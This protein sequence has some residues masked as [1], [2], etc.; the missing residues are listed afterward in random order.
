MNAN[1]DFFYSSGPSDT[2]AVIGETGK[3]LRFPGKSIQ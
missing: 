2:F 1:Y 3:I